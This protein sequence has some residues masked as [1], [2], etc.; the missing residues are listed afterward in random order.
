MLWQSRH[1]C[2]RTSHSST[3]F[4][5]MASVCTNVIALV[6]VP[7]IGKSLQNRIKTALSQFTDLA[8]VCTIVRVDCDSS[9]LWQS[10]TTFRERLLT[11][12]S[13]SKVCATVREAE[14]TSVPSCGKAFTTVTSLPS[15][16]KVCTNVRED[17]QFP[18]VAKF[19]QM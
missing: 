1:N 3:L 15:C 17:S 2:H 11:V 10:L 12:P 14:L 6:S 18:L 13:C 7:C 16:S 5:I 8:N 9:V 19:V 4:H